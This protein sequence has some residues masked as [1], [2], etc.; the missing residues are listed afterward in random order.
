MTLSFRLFTTPGLK[1]G[2]I[3]WIHCIIFYFRGIIWMLQSS[4]EPFTITLGCLVWQQYSSIEKTLDLYL[5][6]CNTSWGNFG[7]PILKEEIILPPLCVCVCVSVCFW[8]RHALIVS[9]WVT[10]VFSFFS[11]SQ[12]AFFLFTWDVRDGLFLHSDAVL[13]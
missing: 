6:L 11:P 7:F 2:E 12:R 9:A 3:I 1:S 13:T 4:M 10:H 8:Q 5:D